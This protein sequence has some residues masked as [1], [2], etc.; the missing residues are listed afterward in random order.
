MPT[1]IEIGHCVQVQH[2]STIS[3]GRSVFYKV[4][5]L[6]PVETLVQVLFCEF[7]VIFRSTFSQNASG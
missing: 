6:Q 1:K 2:V 5:G 4:A 7:W 3:P